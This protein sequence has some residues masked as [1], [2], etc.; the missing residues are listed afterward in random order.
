MD[1]FYEIEFLKALFITISIETLVLFIL[2][3]KVPYFRKQNIPNL[4][5]LYTG[6]LSSFATLP[7]VWFI[8]P[9]FISSQTGYI[10]T[11]ESFAVIAETIIFYTFL[12]TRFRNAFILSLLCNVVSFTIGFF[13]FS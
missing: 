1:N 8:F 2:L 5:I 13:F 4:K 9:A 12:K 6:I 10:I 3:R 7:Y 11:S